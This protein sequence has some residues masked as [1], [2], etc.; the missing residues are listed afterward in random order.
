MER[1]DAAYLQIEQT[2]RLPYLR[3][4]LKI[5]R[6]FVQRLQALEM[7]KSRSR[8]TKRQEIRVGWR[9]IF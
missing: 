5:V 9:A 3:L 8:S 7:N 2:D 6:L 1:G 4:T